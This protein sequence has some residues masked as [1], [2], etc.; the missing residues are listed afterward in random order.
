[1]VLATQWQNLRHVVAAIEFGKA[2]RVFQRVFVS[3]CKC[4]VCATGTMANVQHIACNSASMLT[5]IVIPRKLMNVREEGG[6]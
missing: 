2:L 5:L 3:Y 4:K 1:M 6:S